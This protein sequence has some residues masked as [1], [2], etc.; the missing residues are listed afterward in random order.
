MPEN[1]LNKVRLGMAAADDA[2]IIER[3]INDTI[4]DDALD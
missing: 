4:L 2:Q 1:L 3:N